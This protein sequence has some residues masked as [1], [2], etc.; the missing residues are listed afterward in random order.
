M[1]KGCGVFNRLIRP[2]L[3]LLLI[4]LAA[5][6]LA[7][8]S[9][10]APAAPADGVL[11]VRFTPP[12]DQPVR[13]KLTF[14]QVEDGKPVQFVA[15]QELRFIRE[16]AGYL[17][18]IR[19]LTLKIDGQT[20]DMTKADLPIPP[21]L[22]LLFQPVTLELDAAGKVVRVR[23]W[24]KVRQNLINSAPGLAKML[25]TK[26]A[27]QQ[28]MADFFT[29]FFT[30]FT[31]VPAERAPSLMVEGWPQMLGLMALEG[32]AG[33]TYA[34]R[35]PV[36]TLYVPE[37]VDY[38]FQT[39]FSHAADGRGVRI[40]TIGRPD[41]AGAR[42]V[43]TGLIDATIEAAPDGESIDRADMEGFLANPE[44]AQEYDVTFDDVTGLP[45]RARLVDREKFDGLDNTMTVTFERQ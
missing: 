44:L 4:L 30:K 36:E 33:Q 7:Q 6:A 40:L 20:F 14:D 29:K 9:A 31:D 26:P 16:D 15:V 45:I 34:G 28:E 3:A 38:D 42:K 19:W 32:R 41:A 21:S 5:P 8:T 27:E 12:L 10:P 43:Q 17:M 39:R 11:R 23:D 37:P 24:M 22:L 1:Q 18:S 35:R 2:V 25:S 13:Y